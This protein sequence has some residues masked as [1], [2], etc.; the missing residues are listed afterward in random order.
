MNAKSKIG[1]LSIIMLIAVILTFCAVGF[2]GCAA[3]VEGVTLNKDELE[4]IK[5]QSEKL[6][7]TITPEDASD[8]TVT[9]SSDKTS[10]AAVSEDGTVTA[11]S[12]GEATITVS[13]TD[14]G[15]TDTCKVTVTNPAKGIT[16]DKQTLELDK[17]ATG[18]LKATVDPADADDATVT[19]S[20]SDEKVATVT[21]GMVSAVG[22]GSAT[23]TAKTVNGL[24]A[25]AQVTVYSPVTGVTITAPASSKLAVGKT[26]KLETTVAPADATEKGVTWSSSNDKIA[27]VAQDGTVT[28]VAAGK[29]TITAV[30]KDNVQFKDEIELE[31]YVAVTGVSIKDSE[32]TLYLT[33]GENKTLEAVIVPENA[34]DKTVIWSSSDEKVLKVEDGLL[35]AVKAGDAVITVTTNDG[36]FKATIDVHVYAKVTGIEISGQAT[37]LF[38]GETAQLTAMVTPAEANQAI[39]WSSSDDSVAS[40]E[41]GVVT[42]KKEGDVTITATAADGT[43][44]DT[45]AV[46]VATFN[47]KAG[48]L[49]LKAGLQ[50]KIVLNNSA[51]SLIIITAETDGTL[52]YSFEEVSGR[53]ELM[54]K[55]LSIEIKA[56]T[57][58]LPLE[59]KS[60]AQLFV[61]LLLVEKLEESEQIADDT[62]ASDVVR[63]E[64]TK[65]DFTTLSEEGINS[66]DKLKEALG[67]NENI[68]LTANIDA[69]GE[70][71]TGTLESFSSVFDGNG[72]AILNLNI[73]KSGLFASIIT[74]AEIKDIS[75]INCTINADT[76]NQT[77]LIA[78]TNAETGENVM[79]V[80]GIDVYNL[81]IK[82]T[83]GRYGGLF[84]Y[85]KGAGT[86]LTIS[87]CNIDL[88][89]DR[90]GGNDNGGL[91]GYS[92]Y[93]SKITVSGCNVT[94]TFDGSIGN[95]NGGLVGRIANAGTGTLSVKNCRISIKAIGRE[96]ESE[97]EDGLPVVSIPKSNYYGSIAGNS[98]VSIVGEGNTL[99]LEMDNCN[100][101]HYGGV[102]GNL[103]NNLTLTN[104]TVTLI[105]NNTAAVR[106][107]GIAGTVESNT[108]MMV[109]NNRINTICA[110]V[111]DLERVGGVIGASDGSGINITISNNYINISFKDVVS[112]KADFIGGISGAVERGTY[113]LSFNYVVMD[114]SGDIGGNSG[115]FT[116]PFVSETEAVANIENCIFVTLEQFVNEENNAGLYGNN[117]IGGI[118]NL[119]LENI[120]LTTAAAGIDAVL[121]E[122]FVN[123]EVNTEGSTVWAYDEEANSLTFEI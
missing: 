120:Q 30:S 111:I 14:G 50:N 64:W 22:G 112:Q 82:G 86:D 101:D 3:K 39:T 42:A 68:T 102:A 85:I 60:N 99:N 51:N 74:P 80:S 2:F 113:E 10:V 26:L 87:D 11:V 56:G 75:F 57:N 29:V 59:V 28:A 96:V 116:G 83:A 110:G 104:N 62:L 79:K 7:A 19:W 33:A 20:S 25:T 46:K 108:V 35:T 47:N 95:N 13:T 91:I 44:K 5:G 34:T 15:F 37:Q 1:R 8:M 6:T 67:K 43:T 17:G 121:A 71:W 24:T 12:T 114:V 73:E 115:A 41:N 18:E 98:A 117:Y 84:G 63:L 58:F 76:N 40:V 106:S 119:T 9:W 52:Y 53:N 123:P 61:N 81:V 38:I 78:G 109:K 97:G 90:V 103:S 45:Y 105:F 66:W 72:F 27:T 107:G 100:G 31:I 54:E 48:E 89:F 70:A 92:D 32:N 69:A 49:E 88:K 55:G 94:V 23:I 16:L 36:A 65:D 93:N 4:L 21:N 118:V 122:N 77:G